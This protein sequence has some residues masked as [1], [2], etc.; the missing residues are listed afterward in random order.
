[1]EQ[2]VRIFTYLKVKNTQL[3][4]RVL[5]RK[6]YERKGTF[7]LE[8]FTLSIKGLVKQKKMLL[9]LIYCIT[10]GVRLLCKQHVSVV[11]SQSGASFYYFIMYSLV[12][13]TT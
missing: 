8:N 12:A 3:H 2:V 11:A 9:W 7:V 13:L 4:E 6:S 10:I 5:H 1:M